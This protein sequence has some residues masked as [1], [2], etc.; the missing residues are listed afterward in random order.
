MPNPEEPLQIDVDHVDGA[1]V[2]GLAGEL[3]L[4]AEEALTAALVERE[5]AA[6]EGI[7]AVDLSGL[8]FMDS[9]GSR[10]LI[11]AHMRAE[12]AGRRFVIVAG[13]GPAREVLERSGLVHH[14]AVAGTRWDIP[15]ARPGRPPGADG[16][17]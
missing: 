17:T 7:I 15:A 6:G 11:E 3:D 10:V 12:S 4:A 2:L 5:A 1:T 8:E 14:L 9:T 13:P 16:A